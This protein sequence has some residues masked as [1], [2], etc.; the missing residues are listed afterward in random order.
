MLLAAAVV[1]DPSPSL[2]PMQRTPRVIRNDSV[3][4][5]QETRGDAKSIIERVYRAAKRDRNGWKT[6]A[7]I[8]DAAFQSHHR[9]A[10]PAL[11]LLA[12]GHYG[13]RCSRTN[14]A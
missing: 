12:G 11:Q 8:L 5:V 14:S 10:T 1:E 9:S 6:A 4:N 3:I 13:N 2:S 7:S